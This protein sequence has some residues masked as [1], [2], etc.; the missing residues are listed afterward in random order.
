MKL[1]L[2][3]HY[4]LGFACSV[5]SVCYYRNGNVTPADVPCRSSGPSTC[6]PTG[7]ACLSNN[8]CVNTKTRN[9]TVGYIRGSCT[10][11]SWRAGEC[12]GFC[13]RGGKP[14][15]DTLGGI[16]PMRKCENTKEDI[17]YCV[18]AN[19]EAVDCAVKNDAII[20]F[21][22]QPTTVTVIGAT[23]TNSRGPT[24]TSTPVE[25]LDAGKTA[26]IG[27]GI[28]V[29]IGVVLLAV[30]SFFAVRRRRRA[31][32]AREATL[33]DQQSSRGDTKQGPY[34][35]PG[36]MEAPANEIVEAPN[37]PAVGKLPHTTLPT[38]PVELPALTR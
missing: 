8:I 17:Y 24:A 35:N 31:R 29:P 2:S 36:L 23:Q 26:A 27:A 30:V 6:C 7:F 20:S 33:R 15:N 3:A 28:G 18:N 19:V 37:S 32:K 21:V 11:K 34:N 22:G 9:E 13:I 16:Q 10:D 14:W 1:P 38:S 4:L 5:S 12:P 25:A